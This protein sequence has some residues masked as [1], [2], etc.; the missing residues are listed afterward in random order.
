MNWRRGV[1][2]A[3]INLVTAVPLIY[4]LAVRDAQFLKEREQQSAVPEMLPRNMNREFSPLVGV[5]IVQ[6]QEEQTVTF[7]PCGLWAHYPP[8]VSVV[9]LGN[10]PAFVLSQ[11]RE[12]CPP[13]WSVAG[14]LGVR[15]AG[16]S[17][18]DNFKAMRKVDAALCLMIAIQW[19]LIGSFPLSR[20]RRWWAEPGAF[21]TASTGVAAC[22]AIIPVV[23]DLARLPALVAFGGWLWWFGLLLWKPVHLAWQS[24]LGGL[25]RLNN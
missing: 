1:L 9:Q 12:A 21:I 11:W 25:R 23:D 22:I 7:N 2:L 15:V 8:Q 5:R 13:R 19:F 4:L 18:P 6:V 24:T 10:L 20:P 17:T 14:M 3:G 16:W